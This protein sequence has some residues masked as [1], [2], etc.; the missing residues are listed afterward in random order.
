M[1]DKELKKGGCSAV[2]D[3]IRDVFSFLR[4]SYV[5]FCERNDNRNGIKSVSHPNHCEMRVRHL[6]FL[7]F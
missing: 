1:N 5:E 7:L 3:E 6:N 4:R 2:N